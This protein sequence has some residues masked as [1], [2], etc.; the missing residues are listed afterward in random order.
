MGVCG[1]MHTLISGHNELVELLIEHGA[2]VTAT[3]HNSSTPLHLA[4]LKGH[5]K[6]TVSDPQVLRYACRNDNNNNLLLWAENKV[7]Y[8]VPIKIIRKF[9]SD[10]AVIFIITCFMDLIHVRKVAIPVFV[11]SCPR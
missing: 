6:C 9:L 10:T 2:I 3:D 5:Q 11:Q 8:L 7:E 4:C 1:I